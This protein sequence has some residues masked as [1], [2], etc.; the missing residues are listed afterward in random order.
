MSAPSPTGVRA[1]RGAVQAVSAPVGRGGANRPAD[2]E[3]VQV[4]LVV[5]SGLTLDA[6]L[7]PGPVDGLAGDAVESALVRLQRRIGLVPDGRLD[8]GGYTVRRLAALLSV[9]ED[10]WSFPFERSSAW[11]YHGP[12]AGMRAF[13]SSRSGGRRLHAAVDLYFPD[14]QPV[15]AVAPGRVIAVYPFYL[16]THAVE[17]DHGA[18]VARY[19]ELAPD[20]DVRPGDV[21]RA[22][23]PLGRVGVLTKANG[24]RLGVPSMMLHFELYD[25]TA[26][27]RLTDPSRGPYLRRRD[28]VDPTG[29][30]ARA[31]LPSPRG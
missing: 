18:Y 7:H 13:G 8:P 17:V 11:P 30:L 19:G 6:R 20:V 24:Q 15:L 27:G 10:P 31:P 23:Q 25:K 4:A 5:A 3:A 28:L 26:E 21:V 2:V 16:R 12:G 29:F 22:R 9:G 14:F 1:A